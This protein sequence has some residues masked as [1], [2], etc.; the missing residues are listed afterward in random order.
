MNHLRQLFQAVDDARS[1]TI[2]RVRRH[3]MQAMT[4]DG[5]QTGPPLPCLLL[6]LRNT[7]G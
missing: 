6:L 5:R 4:L 3:D 1:W 2:Q 7:F